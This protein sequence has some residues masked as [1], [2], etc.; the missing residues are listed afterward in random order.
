MNKRSFFQFIIA[1]ILIVG[2][3]V[4][5][6]TAQWAEPPA[7][8]VA[9]ANNT[10]APVNV[11]ASTQSKS[12]NLI[13]NAGGT[14]ASGLLVPRGDI[15][16]GNTVNDAAIGASAK[17]KALGNVWAD[18][19]CDR[20]G[21]NCKSVTELGGTTP[22]P[23]AISWVRMYQLNAQP[24]ISIAPGTINL[25]ITPA[26]YVECTLPADR[27]SG[28]ELEFK[29]D[30]VTYA[31]LRADASNNNGGRV[32]L[33]AGTSGFVNVAGKTSVSLTVIKNT[34][35]SGGT[36]YQS[37][38]ITNS[39]MCPSGTAMKGDVDSYAIFGV[40]SQTEAV[41]APTVT[42]TASPNPANC[43]T[44]FLGASGTCR[45]VLS[46]SSSRASSCTASG[47]WSGSKVLTGTESISF[48]ST[49][50]PNIYTLTCTG[51]GGSA[52]QSVTVTN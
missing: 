47:D 41:G 28:A 2:T 52:N 31:K 17:V 23:A 11:G 43:T 27:G 42:L 46:W 8:T 5:A 9:P 16:V 13:L 50:S 24:T 15:T 36:L 25:I 49:A 3:S 33:R 19:Y 26:G 12:G 20:V 7:G 37:G 6:V 44:S 35:N 32:V 18:K 14:F 22:P 4:T 1:L 39:V 51:P 48:D 30:G 40:Q 29:A 38:P 45:S 34:Y 10:P 21:G